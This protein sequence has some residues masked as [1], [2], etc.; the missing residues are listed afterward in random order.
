MDNRI[1]V[2]VD[3]SEAG[4]RAV[5]AGVEL[6]R[7]LGASL[8]F[9]AVVDLQQLSGMD[10]ALLTDE[11]VTGWQIA[12]RNRQLEAAKALASDLETRCRVLQGN[13]SNALHAD[14]EHAPPRMVVVGR[15]GLGAV[16]AW[17]MGSVSRYLSARSP[18][19]VLVVG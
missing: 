13:A 19:P 3:G 5:E 11:Q 7:G 18:V 4:E 6:A 10:G 1:M 17:F 2:C 12:V 14:L 16:E 8:D 15:T 9:V